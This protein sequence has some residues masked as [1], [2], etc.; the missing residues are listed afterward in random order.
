M[1]ILY[2]EKCNLA[3][4]ATTKKTAECLFFSVITAIKIVS[5][6]KL[7][8]RLMLLQWNN[9]GIKYLIYH[10]SVFSYIFFSAVS[11]DCSKSCGCCQST[12]NKLNVLSVEK[13][14]PANWKQLVIGSI[15]LSIWVQGD[16]PGQFY[17]HL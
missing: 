10:T 6:D 12:C 11:F 8:L 4:L 13:K 3:Y 14:K 17:T 5:Y 9:L 16:C 7:E 15:C 1:Q 2:K